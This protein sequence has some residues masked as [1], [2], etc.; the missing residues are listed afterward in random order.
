MPTEP[1]IIIV[2]GGLL[3]WLFFNRSVGALSGGLLRE[4]GNVALPASVSIFG[5]LAP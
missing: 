3:A 4:I 2:G 5:G 1:I